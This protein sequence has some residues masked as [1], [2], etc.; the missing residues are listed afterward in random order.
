MI[1]V[2]PPNNRLEENQYQTWLE[3]LQVGDQVSIQVF[4]P[5]GNLPLDSKYEYWGYEPLT[6]N[7]INVNR[8]TCSGNVRGLQNYLHGFIGGCQTYSNSNSFFRKIFY[9]RIVPFTQT[10]HFDAP[11][12]EPE[13]VGDRIYALD[14]I[15]DDRMARAI[16]IKQLCPSYNYRVN[17]GELFVLFP[18]LIEQDDYSDWLLQN[19]LTEARFL[20]SEPLNPRD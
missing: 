7:H 11:V 1:Q 12:Y 16:R 14:Y 15:G 10:G 17:D 20:Y 19:Q 13:W 9:Q 18:G 6:I 2:L 4:Y 5:A 8:I 3:N